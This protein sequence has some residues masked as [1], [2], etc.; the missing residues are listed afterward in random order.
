MADSATM[1]AVLFYGPGDLRLIQTPVPCAE[2]GGVVVQIH[3]ALTCGTDFKAYR[4]QGHPVL[5]ACMPLLFG[6]EMAGTISEVGAGV[7]AFREGQRVVALNSAP[8][9]CLLFL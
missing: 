5:L 3:T 4:R 7:T 2:D 9:D 1:R 6:H 8:C